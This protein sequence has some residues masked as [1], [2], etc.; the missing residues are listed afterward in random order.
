MF[1]ILS[2]TVLTSDKFIRVFMVIKNV[3]IYNHPLLIMN[4][5]KIINVIS[6]IFEN[7][8]KVAEI[9]GG[10]RDGKTERAKRGRSGKR[11]GNMQHRL[12]CK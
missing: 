12:S 4:V 1:R 2:E 3:L 8:A 5:E 11:S 7:Y 6:E 10:L 9:S